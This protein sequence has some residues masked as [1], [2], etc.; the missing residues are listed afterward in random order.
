MANDWG[1]DSPPLAPRQ[2]LFDSVAPPAIRQS[3]AE[4]ARDQGTFIRQLH[5]DVT[6]LI[7]ASVVPPGFDMWGFCE[8]MAQVLLWLSLSDQPPRVVVD[9]LRQLGGQNRYEGFPDSQYSSVAHALIQTVH[10]LTANS[11]S[12]STGSAWI[13][14]FMSLQPHLLA[15]AQDA[16]RQAAAASEAAARE[17][18]ARE[19]A[20]QRAAAELEA[21]RNRAPSGT[22]D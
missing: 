3:A 2:Q 10:Y 1:Y 18:A 19:A 4:L 16:A 6:S 12:T 7:P 8:R 13:S 20:T 9:A 11:W 15:G 21:R 22:E 5:A 17:A 14:F